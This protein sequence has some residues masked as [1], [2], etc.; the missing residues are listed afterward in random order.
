LGEAR[1]FMFGRQ[2]DG[3]EYQPTRDV[4]NSA[5]SA[6]LES[7]SR[8]FAHC[9]HFQMRLFVQFSSSWQDFSW[10]RAS[11]GPSATCI[12]CCREQ[13]RHRTARF[14]RTAFPLLRVHIV[15][16]TECGEH[17]RRATFSAC[18]IVLMV[19]LGLLASTLLRAQTNLFVQI[20]SFVRASLRSSLHGASSANWLSLGCYS[21][22]V[23]CWFMNSF[24]LSN[25][26]VSY[27]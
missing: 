25:K 3:G 27:F 17:L 11:R 16:A 22:Q 4:S 20:N 24:M 2:T 12:H 10:L 15:G 8:S 23:N 13:L 1:H 26:P 21:F 9:K 18:I 5:I 14:C 7:R 19:S 6:D